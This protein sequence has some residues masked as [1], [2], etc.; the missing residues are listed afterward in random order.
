MKLYHVSYTP[1]QEFVPRIPECR[2]DGEDAITPRICF[3]P[4]IESCIN[5]KPSGM[6]PIIASAQIGI[7]LAI[8]V[9]EIDLADYRREELL[10]PPEVEQN[11]HC[12]DATFNHEYC[13]LCKPRHVT[14]SRK[15]IVGYEVEWHD[16]LPYLKR[17][18]AVESNSKWSFFWEKFTTV[19]NKDADCNIGVDTI[20]C[21]L[22]IEFPEKFLRAYKLSIADRSEK[23]EKNVKYSKM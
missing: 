20:I 8:Y 3:T 2:A 18:I 4:R 13:L 12:S 11:L 7:P 1:V 16:E 14:V 21:D 22:G 19:A 10:T 23:H 6:L 5:A 9:Y 17:L 15:E